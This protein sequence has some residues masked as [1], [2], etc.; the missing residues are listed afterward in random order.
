MTI[1]NRR[2]R[3]IEATVGEADPVKDR[4][5]QMTPEE[6]RARVDELL[7]KQGTSL[8]AEIAK[9]GSLRACIEMLRAQRNRTT[10][11]R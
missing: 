8:N 9:H 3:K 4:I 5:D 11:Q 1:L 10:G 6:R 7:A 2:V